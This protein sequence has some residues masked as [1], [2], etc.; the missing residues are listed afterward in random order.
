MMPRVLALLML[1][2]ILA[3]GQAAPPKA[4]PLDLNADEQ[5]RAVLE[6]LRRDREQLEV[7]AAT[8]RALAIKARKAWET[9]QTEITKLKEEL[10]RLKPAPESGSQP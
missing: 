4:H 9:L 7:D 10:A 5:V 3:W 2:P 8:Q 1:V 6:A